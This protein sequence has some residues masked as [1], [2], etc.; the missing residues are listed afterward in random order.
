M[1]K[2]SFDVAALG[3]G[4]AW[5]IAMV[6]PLALAAPVRA[7]C[8]EAWVPSPSA[9]ASGTVWAVAA[10][11]TGDMI[12]AGGFT[13]AGGVT[14]NNIARYRPST[15]TWS[16]L[17][18]GVNGTVFAVAVLSDGDIVAAGGSFNS[19]SGVAVSNIARYDVASGTWSRMGPANAPGTNS[20]VFS[21]AVLPGDVVIAGGGFSSAGGVAAANIARYD[22]V[23][24][25]WTALGAGT[26]GVAGIV[27][28]VVA[29][30]ATELVVG[31]T[32]TTAGGNAALRL[33]RFNITTNTWSAVGAG[34]SGDVRALTV[35]PNGDVYAGGAFTMSGTQTMNRAA[36]VNMTTGTWFALGGAG[37]TAGVN[38]V[39]N[40]LT[41]TAAGDVIIGGNFSQTGSG[42]TVN[43]VVR[44]RPST[45]TWAT[46]GSGVVGVG[47]QVDGLARM[48]NGDIL[49]GGASLSSAGGFLSQRV[50][51][52]YFSS[53]GT[54][55][56][57]GPSPQVICP[58]VTA[59][60]SVTPSTATPGPFTYQWRKG[61]VAISTI[62]NPSAAT[63]TLTI[64]NASAADVASYDCV[65]TDRCSVTSAAATLGLSTPTGIGTQPQP[66]TACVGGT[67]S[68]SIGGVT[69]SAS[70]LYLWRKNGVLL[71][72][73][74]NP[75]AATTTL[76]LT[77]VGPGDA[78]S[79]DC[80]VSAGCSPATSTAASLAIENCRCNPADIASDD[81][82]P[83]PPIG[84]PGSGNNGVT[85][86]DY[87]LFFA[88]FFDAGLACDIANDD[89]SPLPPFGI[90]DTNNGVTEGDYNL[91]FAIFFDGC[92]L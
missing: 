15:N 53:P 19:A 63:A 92:A 32:F 10:H 73:V 45:N 60:F 68:F 64:S 78:G 25:A 76:I 48:P 3:R 1:F 51:R 47:G 37:A 42:T 67:A 88:T 89:G 81:G 24:N 75:S 27:Y 12:V 22:P 59:V 13:S 5:A 38:G 91:F 57:A 18:T 8:P 87:N 44:F 62:A 84:A 77:N 50:A 55:I 40:A 66:A 85:E 83:L 20:L 29:R 58:T 9:V 70:P 11:P 4:L 69:G 74:A 54:S 86:G 41:T 17:G 14:V 46:L 52:Y 33:A 61:G 39:V 72:A 79:Y 6:V 49:V 82:Q 34:A 90:F 7:Q 31:G 56:S 26:N 2:S 23:T 71:D 65:V 36:L 30:S 35:M 16:A 80:L 21:L 28:A 43:R